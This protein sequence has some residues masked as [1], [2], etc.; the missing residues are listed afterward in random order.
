MIINDKIRD[1]V[2][3]VEGCAVKPHSDVAC[4]SY[5]RELIA[6]LKL[7]CEKPLNRERY[8]SYSA[9]STSVGAYPVTPDG[10]AQTFNP[11]HEEAAFLDH[12]NRFG[13]VVSRNIVQPEE[14]TTTVSRINELMLGLSDGKCDLSRP[15]TYGEIPVDAA[16]VPVLSRGFFEIYHDASLA[17]LRQAVRAYIH[18]VVLWGTTDLWTTFDRFG[19]KLPAHSESKALPLHVD[20]NPTTN[21]CFTSVQGVLALVDCSVERGTLLAVPGSKQLF[22]EYK[23]MPARGEFVKLDTTDPVADLLQKHAQ[24]IPLRAGSL[25]SWDSR[26][27]HA[28]TDNISDD[29]RFVAYIAAG[30]ARRDRSDLVQAREEAFQT[31][32]ARYNHDA[33]LRVSTKP[34]YTNPSL[35][36]T[37]RDPERLN[38]LG[39]LLYGQ[40]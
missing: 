1:L 40:S 36:A 3:L 33:L 15:E 37:V 13:V 7:N 16:G 25:V 39:K 38:L 21:P 10:Y 14:C 30:L 34:R 5:I 19:V 23:R 28:N 18:H 9:T 12:W 2:S 17:K 20:Q 8:R 35:T 31:G 27:T 24:P 26:T 29:T 22:P 4:D 32:L 11:L 6:E